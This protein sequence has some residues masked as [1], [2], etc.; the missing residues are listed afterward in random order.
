MQ[1]ME[2]IQSGS[3]KEIKAKSIEENENTF[4]IVHGDCHFGNL[5]DRNGKICYFDFDMTTKSFYAL[6]LGC[7]LAEFVFRSGAI[8]E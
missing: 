5:L 8:E 1:T 2:E 7:M 3:Y 4:G 6:D